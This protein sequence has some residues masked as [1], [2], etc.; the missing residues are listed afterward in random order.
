MENMLVSEI[1]KD[2]GFSEILGD[3]E[4]VIAYVRLWLHYIFPSLRSIY[5]F[6]SIACKQK[7]DLKFTFAIYF[8]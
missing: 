7:H 3:S 1:Y 2:K 6:C 5:L 4:V 8:V